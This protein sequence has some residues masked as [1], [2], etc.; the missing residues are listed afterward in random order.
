M[1]ANDHLLFARAWLDG[2]TA[3]A[4]VLEH[5]GAMELATT[6][7]LVSV[8]GPAVLAKALTALDVLSGGRVVA[9][10]GPG[11]SGSEWKR[12]VRGGDAPRSSVRSTATASSKRG[13]RSSKGTPAAA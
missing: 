6:V 11:S 2:P 13:Q 9:G 3:L 8:R 12:S 4:A 1:A 10:V 5:S 7:A